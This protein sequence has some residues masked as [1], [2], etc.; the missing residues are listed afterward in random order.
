MADRL[1]VWFK[2][3]GRQDV[4]LA[5]GKGA[6]LGDMVQAGLPVPPGFVITAPAYRLLIEK[7]GL[8]SRIDELLEGLDRTACDALQA[9]EPRLRELFVHVPIPEEL[10]REILEAYRRLGTEEPVA[11]R[12]SATAED[13]AG[14]SFAGQ[15]DTILN[16]IGEEE[17]LQAVRKCWSSL[18]TSQAIFYRC[19]QGFDDR[20]VSMGVVVQKMIDSEKSGVSFTADPVLRNRYQMVVEAVWGLGEGIVSGTITPDHYKVDKE[21]YE[22]D[23]EF[24]P[25]KK[26]MFCRK[27]PCEGQRGGVEVLPVPEDRADVRVLTEDELRKLIDLGN[28]VEEHFGCP[29]DIEWC[30][31]GNEIYLLQSRPITCL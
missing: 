24:I 29:Q 26:I 4:A 12:S 15:Q 10:E 8:C 23:D 6:N 31:T 20:E 17:L 13:L 5:G 16:V 19:R 1:T 21:T 18:F 2:E 11:V 3:I 9:V 28:L 30:I 14:A 27:A 22:I 25:T 7:V